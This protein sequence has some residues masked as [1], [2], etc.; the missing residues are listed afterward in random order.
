MEWATRRA[1]ELGLEMFL[2]A[3]P[4][5]SLLYSSHGFRL[6][7]GADLVPDSKQAED[8][9]GWRRMDEATD[10][11]RCAVMKRPVSGQWGFPDKMNLEF[12]LKSNVWL[13]SFES[14]S[15]V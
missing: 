3:S 8:N 7:G 13:G 1:D 2:E 6:M 5:G 10:P 15:H 12:D 4:L 11:L 9:E 14:G